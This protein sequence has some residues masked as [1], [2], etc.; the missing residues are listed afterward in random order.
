M[1]KLRY[2]LVEKAWNK[3]DRRHEGELP[4]ADIFSVYD[5]S[6]HPDVHIGKIGPDDSTA[7]F[8]ESFEMHHNTIHDYNPDAQVS[9]DEFIE[10]YAYISSMTESDHV[11]DQ[12]VTGPWNLDSRNNYEAL[13]YAGC[14]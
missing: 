13:P 8:R 5:G 1:S 7:D 6:R 2:E 4:L 12:A 11:F 10:F 9:K 14:A 3:L